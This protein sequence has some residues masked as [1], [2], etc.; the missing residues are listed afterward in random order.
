MAYVSGT[1][2]SPPDPIK[3]ALADT[4]GR[5]WTEGLNGFPSRGSGVRVPFPAPINQMGLVTH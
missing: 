4:S 1:T 3:Y 2:E 5:K